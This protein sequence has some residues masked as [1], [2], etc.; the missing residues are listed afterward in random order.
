MSQMSLEGRQHLRMVARE[1]DEGQADAKFRLAQAEADI[2]EAKERR[3]AAE[4]AKVKAAKQQADLEAFEPDL[5]LKKL[6]RTGP[7]KAITVKQIQDQIKWHRRIGG[8]VNI[9]K[10][11]D[12]RKKEGAWAIMVQAVQRHLSGTSAEKGNLFITL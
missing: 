7:T 3:G 6:Q 4:K 11:V 8:D 10:N 5:D 1:R 2:M 12:R 9:P